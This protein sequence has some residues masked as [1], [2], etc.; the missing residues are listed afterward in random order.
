MALKASLTAEEHQALGDSLKGEYVQDGDGFKLDVETV[1]GLSLVNASALSTAASSATA[2]K[3]KIERKL[4]GFQSKVG[5]FDLD[6]LPQA[7]E[8]LEKMAEWDPDE[9]L[10]KHKESFEASTRQAFETEYRQKAKV[11]ET[12]S[13][14]KDAII[15]SRTEQLKRALF[16]SSALQLCAQFNADPSIVNVMRDRRMVDWEEDQESMELRLV[17]V[18]DS[19]QKR[20][21]VSGKDP[22]SGMSLE[23]LFKECQQAPDKWGIFF[24]PPDKAGSGAGGSSAIVGG[25]GDNPWD[26]KT[27]NLTKQGE[28]FR[29]D[30]ALAKRLAAA[31]GKPIPEIPSA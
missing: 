29:K 10:K 12:E 5:D 24:K 16:E 3:E 2:E 13:E 20:Y 21:S 25:V 22:M 26:D 14:K 31:A 30:P 19:G 18:D 11:F 7:R 27:F 6:L 23:E 4:K 28:I 9:K 8:A 17:V 1:N 15:G